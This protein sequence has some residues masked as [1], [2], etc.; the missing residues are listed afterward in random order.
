MLKGMGL[1]NSNVSKVIKADDMVKQDWFISAVNFSQPIDMFLLIG[2]NIARPST[3]GSTFKTV[4]NAIRA[5]HKD[6]PIQIFGAFRR[7]AASCSQQRTDKEHHQAATATSA[8]LPS[9]TRAA[10]RWSRAATARR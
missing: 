8:T 2:H 3:G 5:V 10:R 7:A 9:S 6:T 4:Y 1:G